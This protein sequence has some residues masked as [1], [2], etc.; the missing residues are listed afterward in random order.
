M[1]KRIFDLVFGLIVLILA[2]PVM[3]LSILMV[4]V[5]DGSP[6]IFRQKRIGKDGRVFD[7]FKIRTMVKNAEASQPQTENRD[8][9]GH[10]IYKLKDDPRVTRVGRV[11]RRFSIDELP[12]LFNVL[13]GTMS[14]VGPRPEIPHLIDEYQP[15]QH[16]RFSVLP[17]MT[18]W[19]QINSRNIQPMYLRIEDDLYY[20]Q[21][22]SIWLDLQI[23]VRTIWVVL[24][25]KGAY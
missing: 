16:R 10:L 7:M 17:G 15:W 24:I 6:V 23:I 11:L 21:N 14:L 5:E 20:I 3:A 25:G 19:W 4:Y 1:L 13:A 18:G 12:Q 2:L 8:S 22:C 9:D